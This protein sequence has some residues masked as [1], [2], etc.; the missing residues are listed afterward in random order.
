MLLRGGRGVRAQQ[1]MLL[2]IVPE[3]G[4]DVDAH[5]P[6]VAPDLIWGVRA[7]DDRRDGWMPERELQRRRPERYAVLPA[8]LLDAARSFQNLWFGGLIPVRRSGH[9]PDRQDAGG[10]H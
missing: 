5:P 7:G 2:Q 3:L 6:Q 10:E 9:R 8:D 1:P 4:G